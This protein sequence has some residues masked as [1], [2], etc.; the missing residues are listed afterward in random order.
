MYHSQERF[1]QLYTKAC[2]ESESVRLERRLLRA[3]RSDGVAE[4]LQPFLFSL[5]SAP[6]NALWNAVR[7]NRVN[8]DHVRD[9]IQASWK[10]SNLGKIVDLVVYQYA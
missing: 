2:V 4:F 6:L 7:E 3:V 9:V 5:D 1:D 10:D 8:A